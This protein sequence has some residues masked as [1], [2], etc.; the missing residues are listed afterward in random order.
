MG[1]KSLLCCLE[2]ADL[3]PFLMSIIWR[4]CM[5]LKVGFSLGR[6]HGART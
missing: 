4:S 5:P 3:V 1:F 6:L 2:L